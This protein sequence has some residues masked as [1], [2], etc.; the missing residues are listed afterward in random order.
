MWRI[1]FTVFFV[2]VPS[3]VPPLKPLGTWK[4]CLERG[5]SFVNI[6]DFTAS[7]ATA[8]ASAA[9]AGGVYVC[10]RRMMLLVVLLRALAWHIFGLKT[11][12]F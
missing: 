9:E 6:D 12:G 4:A 1:R 2:R 7:R 11:R 5:E 10:T 3:M 8:A